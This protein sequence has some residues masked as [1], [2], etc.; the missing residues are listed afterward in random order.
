VQLYDLANDLAETRN[1]QAEKTEVVATLTT[2]LEGYISRGRSTPGEPQ[3]N[4]AAVAWR[5]ST[6]RK[7]ER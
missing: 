2:L 6:P 5:D 7:K 4:D 1:L 3:R